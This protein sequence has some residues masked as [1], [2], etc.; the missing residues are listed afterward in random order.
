MGDN[1]KKREDL[2]AQLAAE[3]IGTEAYRNVA[4][5]LARTERSRANYVE[6]ADFLRLSSISLGYNANALAQRLTK[7]AVKGAKLL[8]TAQNLLL[9]TNY[10]GIEPQVEANGGTRQTRGMGSLSRDVTNA[11]SAKTFTGTL[12]IEF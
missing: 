10:S 8:F 11:P 1:L 7:G 5:Q 6:K 3:T 2:R 9:F 4:E 12:Q